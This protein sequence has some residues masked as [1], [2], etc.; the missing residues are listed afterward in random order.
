[1]TM[2]AVLLFLPVA[3]IPWQDQ[4][5][6]QKV[7]NRTLTLWPELSM[8]VSE[9]PKYFKQVGNWVTDRAGPISASVMV[10]TKILYYVLG[11]PPQPNYVLGSKSHIFLAGG[12]PD[13]PREFLSTVCILPSEREF[14]ET[15][16]Q[17]LIDLKNVRGFLSLTLRIP[18]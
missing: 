4:A 13:H 5:R 17:S 12:R 15:F 3:A 8:L 7:H 2:L 9:P 16:E 18:S 14:L 1:M 6:L 11:T 10:K